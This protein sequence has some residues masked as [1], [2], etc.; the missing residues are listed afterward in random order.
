MTTLKNLVT[1]TTNIKD[2]ILSILEDA[3]EKESK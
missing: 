2:E 1:E 3:I